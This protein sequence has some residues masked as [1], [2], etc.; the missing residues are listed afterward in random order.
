[1]PALKSFFFLC[2]FAFPSLLAAQNSPPELPPTEF[3]VRF[4]YGLEFP[5]QNVYRGE[6]FA[7]FEAGHRLG[8]GG[9]ANIYASERVQFSPYL[10]FEHVFWPKGAGYRGAC[11][12]DSFPTFVS[13]DDTIPGRNFRMYNIVLEPSFKVHSPKMSV[14]FRFIPFFSLNFRTRV[15]NYTNTCGV[16]LQQEWIPYEEAELRRMSSLNFGLGF[17]IVKEVNVTP[18]S[19]LGLEVGIRNIFTPTLFVNQE[20]PEAPD[21]SLYPWGFFVNLSFFR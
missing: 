11:D 13:V 20:N 18:D 5:S 2:L 17:S 21:F 9:Y 6:D 3:G 1:M 4:G 15:E 12:L 16:S 8:F 10:G 7:L 14:W 19:F